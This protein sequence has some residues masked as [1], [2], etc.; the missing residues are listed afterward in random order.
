MMTT[1]KEIYPHECKCGALLMLE[2][3]YSN[4]GMKIFQGTCSNCGTRNF[5]QVHPTKE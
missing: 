3:Q 4:K 1:E 2:F 5:E